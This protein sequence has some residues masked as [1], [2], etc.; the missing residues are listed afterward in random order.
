MQ[1]S[2]S[3]LTAQQGST[4]TNTITLPSGSGCKIP[5]DRRRLKRRSCGSAYK[6]SS[7]VTS[8]P[9]F[10]KK[11]FVFRCMDGPGIPKSFTRKEKDIIARGFVSD[12]YLSATEEEVRQEI[13]AVLTNSG[14]SQ[15][16]GPND[17]EFIDVNGKVAFVPSIKEGF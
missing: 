2:V 8:E 4:K 12:I 16:V 15:T 6:S 1:P 17:F 13:H 7:S 5:V 9:R 14:L 11:L 10:S 3:A